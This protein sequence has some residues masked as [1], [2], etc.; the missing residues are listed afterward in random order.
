LLV[1]GNCMVSCTAQKTTVEMEKFDKQSIENLKKNMDEDGNYVYYLQDSTEIREIYHKNSYTR[2]VRGKDSLFSYWYYYYSNGNLEMKE[3]RFGDH[4]F[5]TK[6][7][8]YDERGRLIK[9]TDYDAPFT[10]TWADVV[11]FCEEHGIDYKRKGI[12]RNE[13]GCFWH[14]SNVFA[15]FNGD[16]EPCMYVIFLDGKTGK[17]ILLNKYMGYDHKGDIY[18][19]IIDETGEPQSSILN[20]K[21]RLGTPYTSVE[22]IPAGVHQVYKGVAYNKEDWKAF[23]KTLP[24]WER[25]F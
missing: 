8:E 13:E 24:W 25:W 16:T 19:T 14:F 9:I 17:I 11:K 2:H 1:S 3:N 22:E 20:K 5:P 7:Y 15:K 18:E 4:G 21:K 6:R 23:L 12:G 10:F